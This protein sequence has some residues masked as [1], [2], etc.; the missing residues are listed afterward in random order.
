MK[1]FLSIFV[2]A[3][4][5]LPFTA[6]ALPSEPGVVLPE[7]MGTTTDLFAFIRIVLN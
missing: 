6:L 7:V 1:K 2:L 3:L 5:V 4:L